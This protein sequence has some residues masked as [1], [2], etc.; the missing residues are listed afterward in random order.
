[1]FDVSA[2]AFGFVEVR[3]FAFYVYSEG[4]LGAVA[5]A[6]AGFWAFEIF[7]DFAVVASAFFAAFAV[8]AHHVSEGFAAFLVEGIV[9][10][11]S[12]MWRMS[13]ASLRWVWRWLRARTTECS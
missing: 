2:F 3:V 12:A 7:V 6:T 4:G 1:M 11:S 13:A 8:G 9:T 10:A 5:V